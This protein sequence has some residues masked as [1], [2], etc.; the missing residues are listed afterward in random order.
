MAGIDTQNYNPGGQMT[1]FND[2]P[3]SRWWFGTPSAGESQE[4]FN[5]WKREADF[6]AAEAQKNRD[7]ETQMSNTAVQRRMAD[8]QAAGFSPLAMF[9]DVQAGSTPS[10]GAASA[11]SSAAQAKDTFT[12]V[13]KGIVAAIGGIAGKIVHASMAAQTAAQVEHLRETAA[14]DRE[15]FRAASSKD[16]A[17][18]K[19]AT[20]KE[21]GMLRSSTA[22]EVA[23]MRDAAALDRA[24][25]SAADKQALEHWKANRV[26]GKRVYDA[27]G[28]LLQIIE[29][30]SWNKDGTR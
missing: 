5:S 27:A 23:H 28:R 24:A 19:N 10:G 8:L 21:M 3:I 25:L 16:I 17:A 11:H 22:K 30:D 20:A 29:D 2:N 4:A 1:V 9:G 18:A 15:L 13:L 26:H 12:P 7:W 14:M 6:N